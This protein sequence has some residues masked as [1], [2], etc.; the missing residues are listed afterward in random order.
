MDSI[1]N[2]R[3]GYREYR[4]DWPQVSRASIIS[5][6]LAVDQLHISNV[7]LKPVCDSHV[8]VL[9]I[10]Y[11]AT[12]ESSTQFACFYDQATQINFRISLKALSAEKS[13]SSLSWE[14]LAC[15]T[16]PTFYK[17]LPG[18]ACSRSVGEHQPQGI[19]I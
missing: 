6:S 18:R 3:R 17:G 8:P 2:A 1:G 13:F 19:R 5:H 11:V 9:F 4:D 14:P 15:G 16:Q 10:H 12:C 7:I